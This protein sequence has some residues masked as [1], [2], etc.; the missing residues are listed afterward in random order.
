[1]RQLRTKMILFIAAC[2]MLAT[3]LPVGAHHAF[4]A[5]FDETKPL[6]LKGTVTKM[7]WINPH[8]WIHITVDNKDGTK[9]DWMVEGGSPNSLFRLGFKKSSLPPGTVIIV[10]GY[11]SKDGSNKAVGRDLTFEDGRRLFLGGSA[12]GANG[13]GQ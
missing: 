1:M 2:G 11:R 10:D 6:T 5:E 8:S 3:A 7:E 4:A 9:T 12:P 13:G